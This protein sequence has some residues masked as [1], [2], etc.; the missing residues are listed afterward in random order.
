MLRYLNTFMNLI[1]GISFCSF[2][3]HVMNTSSMILSVWGL[4]NVHTDLRERQF[5]FVVVNAWI[6]YRFLILFQC[7]R[8]SLV[9][10]TLA[11][12]I[13]ESSLV[14]Y[15]YVHQRAS[16]MAAASL[17]LAMRMNADGEWVRIFRSWSNVLE[18]FT[19]TCFN[20]CFSLYRHSSRCLSLSYNNIP[21]PNVHIIVKI[22]KFYL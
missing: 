2:L 22:N 11:R 9:T 4:Q 20:D 5:G 13:L 10:L 6:E 18:H 8:V 1:F 7:A 12:Y 17:L 16:L 14:D 15:M 21:L 19:I 3:I